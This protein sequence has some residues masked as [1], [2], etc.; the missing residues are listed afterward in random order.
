MSIEFGHNTENRETEKP[1]VSGESIDI[2]TGINDS[3]GDNGEGGDNQQSLSDLEVPAGDWSDEKGAVRKE[4]TAP[5]QIDISEGTVA[6]RDDQLD[7]PDNSE[8]AHQEESE[9][10]EHFGQS[11]TFVDFSDA[12]PVYDSD[13]IDGPDNSE[14]AHPEE[15]EFA[16]DF[17]Q[18]PTFVDFSDAVPGDDSG[19]VDGHDNAKDTQDGNHQNNQVEKASA[20]APFRV[21]L[22]QEQTN[23]LGLSSPAGSGK[24]LEMREGRRGH[25]LLKEM[26]QGLAAEQGERAYEEAVG[27]QTIPDLGGAVGFLAD[28]TR[29]ITNEV[30]KAEIE[31]LKEKTRGTEDTEVYGTIQPDGTVTPN[32]SFGTGE[33]GSP[34]AQRKRR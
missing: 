12:V 3:Q 26:E 5:S 29:G 6:S 21:R 17:G 8:N 2:N 32:P 23:A 24:E 9:L 13:Q 33:S 19:Q 1:S 30:A 22:S 28:P 16:E 11:P 4:R 18:S 14:N 7:G 34:E 27:R 15:S 25:V 20:D 10:A 31:Y